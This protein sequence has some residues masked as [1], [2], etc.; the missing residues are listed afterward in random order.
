[1]ALISTVTGHTS[2]K[3][4]VPPLIHA[5]KPIEVHT[6]ATRDISTIDADP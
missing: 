4:M 2:G 5:P 1:M 3:V 6:T